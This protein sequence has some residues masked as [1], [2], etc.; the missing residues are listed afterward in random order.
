MQIHAVR[1]LEYLALQQDGIKEVFAEAVQAVVNP[2]PS[3]R[4]RSCVLL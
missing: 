3:K 1:Y 4:G 2:T